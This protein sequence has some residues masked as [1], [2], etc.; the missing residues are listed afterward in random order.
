MQTGGSSQS[1][2]GNMVLRSPNKTPRPTH[3]CGKM[4]ILSRWLHR[5]QG[6]KEGRKEGEEE[7]KW[8][9][10]CWTFLI[11]H[12]T[13]RTIYSVCLSGSRKS[14]SK[15]SSSC[16]SAGLYQL[17]QKA[18]AWYC[19]LGVGIKYAQRE[20][21]LLTKWAENINTF[22]ASWCCWNS[23]APRF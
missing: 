19:S 5:M 6:R 17:S 23:M 10:E 20:C 12:C 13:Q 21:M 7:R 14:R 18:H 9:S 8:F 15:S 22:F 2:L 11:S 16:N 4:C 1:R 3:K